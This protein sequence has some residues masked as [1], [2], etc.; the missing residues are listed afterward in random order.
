VDLSLDET[1]GHPAQ[2]DRGLQPFC[3]T[4]TATISDGGG[5]TAAQDLQRADPFVVRKW[6]FID[7]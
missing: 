6:C 7:Q 1:R 3:A 4:K 5:P 2:H